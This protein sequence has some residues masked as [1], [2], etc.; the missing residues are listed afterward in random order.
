MKMN[1]IA[2]AELMHF[3]SIGDMT[4]TE[5]IEATGL[6]RGTIYEY[7]GQ[8]HRRKVVHIAQRLPDTL[9]RHTIKVYKLGA[10]KDAPRVRMTG[11]QRQAVSRTKRRAVNNPLLQLGASWSATSSPVTTTSSTTTSAASQG[12]RSRTSRTCTSGSSPTTT[13]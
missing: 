5:L 12:G 8:L 6:H 7:I 1:A 9:G 3:L 13:P 4:T 2:F 10:G 11:A